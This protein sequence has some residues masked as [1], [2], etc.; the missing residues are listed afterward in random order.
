MENVLKGLKPELVFKYFEEI[1]QIP[2]G[3]GNEKAISNYLKSFGE[4]LGLETIQDDALN[5]IIR[6]PA[7]KGYENC[8]GVILQGHM[9]MV[10]E[11]NKDT[12]HNFVT[13]PIKLRVQDDMIYAT[14]TTLGADNGIAVAMGLAV[15]ASND[16]EH[17]S[18]EVLITTDEEAGMSGAMAL[19]GSNLKG[20]YIINLDSEEEGYLLVSCAGGVTAWTELNAEFTNY[21]SNK[22]GLLV[23]I[24]GLLG[25]HSGIDIIKQRANSNR[26]MG[27]LLNLL[28]VD[29]DL[30]KIQGGSKN[31]AIPRECE[32]IIVVNK[33]DVDKT[34]DCIN[35]ILNIFKHE[36]STS[37]PDITIECSE[38]NIDKVF[39]KETKNNVITLLNL[40]PN[41]IQ[42]MSMD[43]NGLVESST[44]L[45][46]VHTT[47]NLVT[48]ECA[49]R[50]SVKT[51]KE[52]ITNKMDLLAANLG[53]KFRLESDYP[54]WEY[55]KGSKLEEICVETYE[56]LT[57]KKP[58][59]MAIHA[60]LECGLLLDKIPH[61]QAI[62][63]GPDM[64]EVH[65]PNE[66]LSISSTK[67][68][69]DYLVAI[70]KGMN[71]Y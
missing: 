58:I 27:R 37:D 5:I 8:P 31:N 64:F 47:E 22:Q 52:D 51:L 56:K 63:L 30:A 20:E 46:V 34:K 43:I 10:C 11:K 66:H 62:S 38:T 21:D 60:G 15:L 67:R 41:G 50:S 57:G 26:L 61:A 17:P 53:G 44:N 7:T 9:D 13:D 71:Q 33:D 2:R 69:W 25:G 59:I 42:T 70:L 36:F 6:K 19:D 65:T 32:A 55:A 1:S 3:S 35:Q 39:T 24:K 14:G 45:G 49:V 54:A 68:T 12:N 29:Y 40:I 18:L 28:C 16:L 23:E 48:F 4:N